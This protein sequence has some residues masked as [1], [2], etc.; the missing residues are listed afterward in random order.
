V[1]RRILARAC[2][3]AGLLCITA[4]VVLASLPGRHAG[5]LGFSTCASGVLAIGGGLTYL[6]SAKEAAVSV[7]KSDRVA[8]GSARTLA[9]LGELTA[10]WLEGSLASV[11]GYCGP[12]DEETAGLVP[13]L[14]KL[15]R[16]G[17]VTTGSQ[18]GDDGTGYDGARWLQ[19]AAVEGFAGYREAVAITNAA[20]NA[21]LTCVA[22]TP[23]SLPRW[24]YRYDRSVTV[25]TRDGE[26]ETY[27][28]VHL[29]RRHIRHRWI[30]YGICH[31]DAVKALC[32]AWQVTV[33]DPEWGRAGLLWDV[34]AEAL[35]P[36]GRTSS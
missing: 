22:Y 10:R 8:W 2:V 29:P 24:R 1:N 12:P 16:A 27:F 7:S 20:S 13:V 36:H 11:P 6:R 30:G 4:T 25:T 9:G 31:R 18:P 21:G 14:G 15:N 23:A 28:G 17:F 33:I 3:A 19:R 5:A 35:Y 32:A 34:L 26:H